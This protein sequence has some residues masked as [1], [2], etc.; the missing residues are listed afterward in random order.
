[1]LNEYSKGFSQDELEQER[2]DFKYLFL[3]SLLGA[4]L[5]AIGLI[6]IIWGW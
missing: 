4:G 2:K 6:L 5:I 1:M 3:T